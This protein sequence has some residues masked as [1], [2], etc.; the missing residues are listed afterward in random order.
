MTSVPDYCYI[1]T[2]LPP[3][4]SV[5]FAVRGCEKK[6]ISCDLRHSRSAAVTLVCYLKAPHHSRGAGWRLTVRVFCMIVLLAALALRIAAFIL[7]PTAEAATP[8][9]VSQEQQQR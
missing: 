6:R 9:P 5:P 2:Y 4:P 1:I 8:A 3:R 7:D